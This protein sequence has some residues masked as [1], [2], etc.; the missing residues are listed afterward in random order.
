MCNQETELVAKKNNNN[1][2]LNGKT[3]FRA[4]ENVTKS[5][6]KHLDFFQIFWKSV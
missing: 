3:K 5:G 2:F 4:W 6:K 1:T